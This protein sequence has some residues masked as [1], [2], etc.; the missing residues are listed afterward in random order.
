LFFLESWKKIL[1]ED[2]IQEI[3]EIIENKLNKLSEG[4]SGLKLS[5]P[6][7]LINIVK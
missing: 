7:A 2:K 3:F 6:F 5:I 1:P 4:L